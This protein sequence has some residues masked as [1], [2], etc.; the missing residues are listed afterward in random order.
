MLSGKLAASKFDPVIPSLWVLTN[1][2]RFTIFPDKDVSQKISNNDSTGL[3]SAT[4]KKGS[5]DK[6]V[7]AGLVAFTDWLVT[8]PP[9]ELFLFW[10]WS[11]L[12]TKGF[13]SAL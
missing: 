10:D 3:V 7:V 8:I 2:L 1:E 6:L 5:I 12:K 11:P 13:E 4:D 9:I